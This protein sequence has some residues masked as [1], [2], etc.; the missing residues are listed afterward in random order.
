[1]SVSFSNVTLTHIWKDNNEDSSAAESS[2]CEEK[3]RKRVTQES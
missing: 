3:E 1:M 2:D